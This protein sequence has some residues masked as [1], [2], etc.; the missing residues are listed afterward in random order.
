MCKS[1]LLTYWESY[2]MELFMS[3]NKKY[4]L[5]VRYA[6]HR[7]KLSEETKK[8]IGDKNRG[9]NSS[10]YQ[11]ISK[12]S[13]LSK[14]VLQFDLKGN[15]VKR[16]D[17]ITDIKREL[18]YHTTNISKCCKGKLN[19]AYGFNWVYE[20]KINEEKEYKTMSKAEAVYTQVDQFNLSG[21]FIKSHKSISKAAKS[22]FGLNSGISAACAGRQLTSY[23]FIWK[24][25]Q[26]I[27]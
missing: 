12:L 3:R 5:N 10:S 16:W 13:K 7:G 9:S 17:C 11:K 19:S 6:G 21:D 4:G 1:D 18:G 27:P 8:K 24:Y 15:E 23:G 22:V 26:S 20:S 25:K 14:P 2:Y